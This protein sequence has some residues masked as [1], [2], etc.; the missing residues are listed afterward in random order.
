M[1]KLMNM[2]IM[3]MTNTR[4]MDPVQTHENAG[5]FLLKMLTSRAKNSKAMLGT[6]RKTNI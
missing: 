3:K 2:Q 1:M 4:A 6:R 5:K